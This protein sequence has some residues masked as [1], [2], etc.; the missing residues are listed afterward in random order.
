MTWEPGVTKEMWDMADQPEKPA[1]SDTTPDTTAIRARKAATW[2]PTRKTVLITEAE[3][4]ALCDGYDEAQRLREAYAFDAAIVEANE[5]LGQALIAAR[6]AL[7]DLIGDLR[8]TVDDLH[9][10]TP[11]YDV[12]T[13]LRAVIDRHEPEETTEEGR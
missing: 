9:P 2:E 4:D 6:Q 8:R 5:G 10:A 11:M 12:K 13:I 3:R 7:T 1:V